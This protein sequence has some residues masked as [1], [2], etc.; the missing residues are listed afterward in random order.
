MGL[1]KQSEGDVAV[2]V[3]NGVYKQVPV[4]IRDGL[5][6]AAVSGGFVRLKEDGSTSQ[7]KLRLE[8]LD[9]DGDLHRDEMGRLCVPSP[10]RNSRLIGDD[11]KQLL[12][13][14]N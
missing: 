2:V 12:I 3:L 4:F 10:N 13:G 14:S 1:F 6:Y 7:P 9:F 11:R 8:H 5:L